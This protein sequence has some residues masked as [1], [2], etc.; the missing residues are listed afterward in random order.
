MHDVQEAIPS[1][2][3]NARAE[4]EKTRRGKKGKTGIA[5]AQTHQ[6]PA[7]GVLDLAPLFPFHP[8]HSADASII[9]SQHYGAGVRRTHA[10]LRTKPWLCMVPWY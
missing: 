8:L 10:Q 7:A 5:G 9:E 2:G 4:N 6:E 3:D 1:G